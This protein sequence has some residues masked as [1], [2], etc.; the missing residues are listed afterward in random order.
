MIE[1]ENTENKEWIDRDDEVPLVPF[2]QLKPT[3]SEF[4][5]NLEGVRYN[6]LFFSI[7]VL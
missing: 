6:N 1:F 7:K 3:A 2:K 4:A 5:L